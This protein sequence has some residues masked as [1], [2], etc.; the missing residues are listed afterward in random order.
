MT[1]SSPH[2]LSNRKACVHA[3]MFSLSTKG[4]QNQW[5]VRVGPSPSQ[6]LSCIWSYL[7]ADPSKNSARSCFRDSAAPLP[8]IILWLLVVKVDVISGTV[9]R[10]KWPLTTLWGSCAVTGFVMHLKPRWF[11]PCELFPPLKQWLLLSV[12]TTAEQT[13]LL[14]HS[15]K[16]PRS[17]DMPLSYSIGRLADWSALT[18]DDL[19]FYY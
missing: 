6:F 8:R 10:D 13:G 5:P 18:G 16:G 14:L 17:T 3:V 11:F 2:T 7:G 12:T 9:M 4:D 15:E 1:L 19:S